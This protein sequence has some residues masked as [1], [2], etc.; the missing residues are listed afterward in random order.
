MYREP[1]LIDHL[2]GNVGIGSLKADNDRNVNIT[3]IF[4]CV[5]HPLGNPVAADDPSKDVD[6]NRFYGRVFEDD[7]EG[8]LHRACRLEYPVPVDPVPDI[9]VFGREPDK[10]R[11][12]HNMMGGNITPNTRVFRIV[13]IVAH[14]PVVI[15]L[16]CIGVCLLTVDQYFPVANGECIAFKGGD[17][18]LVE[19]QVV[20]VQGCGRTCFGDIDRAVII[21]RPAA[22]AF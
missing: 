12:A 15:L 10:Q 17:D 20:Q 1:G 13:A 5:D 19:G 8:G 7:S 11:F 6:Q 3:N 22:V 2:L 14:H 21:H 16:E 4:I 18:S 9:A